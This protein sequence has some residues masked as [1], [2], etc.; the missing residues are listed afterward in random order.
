MCS[1]DLVGNSGQCGTWPV[2]TVS[3]LWLCRRRRRARRCVRAPVRRRIA[4]AVCSHSVVQ[5]TPRPSTRHPS[6]NNTRSHHAHRITHAH[7]DK[8][9]KKKKSGAGDGEGGADGEDGDEPSGAAGGSGEEEG[10]EEEA[11]S[12]DEV[13]ARCVRPWP[14]RRLRV[15][16]CVPCGARQRPERRRSAARACAWVSPPARLRCAHTARALA[17]RRRAHRRWCG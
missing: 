11:A 1:L 12:D 17:A 16:G 13:C 14:R 6:H 9:K 8:D 3:C 2:H 4:R 15:R 7:R 5:H 10:E